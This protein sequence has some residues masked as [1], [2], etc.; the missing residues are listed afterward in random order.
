MPKSVRFDK[1]WGKLS[2]R[3]FKINQNIQAKE[4]RVLDK[5]GKQI[6]ILNL[7][8]A[9]E[10][11]RTDKLDLVEIAGKANPPV[12]KIVDFKKFLYE[13]EKKEQKEKKSSKKFDI[14][15]IRLTPFIAE[16]DLKTRL[17][18]IEEFLKEGNKVRV[19]VFFRGRQMTK[20]E[21]GFALMEKVKKILE[22]MAKSEGEIKTVGRRIELMFCVIKG[23]KNVEKQTE[24]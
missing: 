9:L 5:S 2:K 8:E 14:K 4:V 21:Y 20:K 17:K 16:N 7:T 12:C 23:V 24:N 18:R 13:E 11:A 15:E 3:Y 10:K 22:P 19:S 1:L 6:G